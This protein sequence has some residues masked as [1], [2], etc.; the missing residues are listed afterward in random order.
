MTRT[1]VKVTLDDGDYFI[2]TINLSLDDARHYYF[3]EV[4]ETIIE[5]EMTGKETRRRIVG[6]EPIS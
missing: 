2:S 6:V 3:R 4:I 1:T 5:D